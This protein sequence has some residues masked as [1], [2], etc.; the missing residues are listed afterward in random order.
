MSDTPR[1]DAAIAASDGQWGFTLRD[2]AQQM[3]RELADLREQIAILRS[4]EKR[5]M[6]FAKTYRL[7]ADE[8]E[9]KI[10]QERQDRKQADLDALRALGERNDARAE[11]ERMKFAILATLEA[12]RHLA[13]GET[14]TLAML[15]AEVPGWS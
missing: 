4:D 13:D 11:L 7:R 12:N 3:E 14:C 9:E 5:L 10:E 8:A 15:K 1:T 6:Q 2:L